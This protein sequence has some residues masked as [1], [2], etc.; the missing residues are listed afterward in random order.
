[1]IGRTNTARTCGA[2]DQSPH[3]SH[4]PLVVRGTCSSISWH[5]DYIK[6]AGFL[7]ATGFA[8]RPEVISI[9]AP[10]RQI[11][12]LRSFP[13]PD[14]SPSPWPRARKRLN[15]T[16][17]PPS[18]TAGSGHQHSPPALPELGVPHWFLMLIGRNSPR[19][20]Q[21]NRLDGSRISRAHCDRAGSLELLIPLMPPVRSNHFLANVRFLLVKRK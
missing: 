19:A 1:M 9:L 2:P 3:V 6:A 16:G 20:S 12:L 5:V 11:V 17:P 8:I 21:S 14:R 13:A 15:I 10:P 18:H 4:H 7:P